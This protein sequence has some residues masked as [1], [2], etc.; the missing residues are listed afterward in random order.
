MSSVRDLI[1]GAMRLMGVTN[2]GEAISA[3]E[4]ADGLV[5]LNE[6]IA[7]WANDSLLCF[8][9]IWE[10]F[11][12]TAGVGIY[13]IGTGQTLN[14]DRPIQIISG[15]TSLNN[16]DFPIKFI[17][18]DDYA[19]KISQ[20]SIQTTW[21]YIGNYD[22]AFPTANIRLWPVPNGATTLFLQSEKQLTAFPN[23]NTPIA[24][25]PGWD[26]ALRYNLAI[27]Y[28]PEF[29]EAAIQA[30]SSP[31][32]TGPAAEAKGLIKLAALRKRPM[33]FTGDR[34][35]RGYDIYSDTSA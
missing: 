10:N 15:Y 17:P 11:P 28:A 7:S 30:V 6:L 14:T 9:R 31:L 33:T 8:A 21:P 34:V 12:I 5:R 13:T 35:Q 27:D 18:D 16:I 29:G 19:L 4:A 32:V 3:D 1:T 2:K 26:K 25:P 24:L 22:N 23:I 20:K